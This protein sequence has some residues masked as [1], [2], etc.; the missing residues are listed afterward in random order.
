M[1]SYSPA[2]YFII[3]LNGKK[4]FVLLRSKLKNHYYAKMI[5]NIN[6]KGILAANEVNK[7]TFPRMSPPTQ[8]IFKCE[9]G[10]MLVF[11]SG[12]FRLM[13]VKE[14]LTSYDNLPFK[15]AQL[16]LQSATVVDDLGYSLNLI[17]LSR[18]LTSRRCCYEPELFPGL[19][20]TDFNPLC[21]N[22]FASGKVIILGVKDLNSISDL[23]TDV[24][25]A[26]LDI[27]L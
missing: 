26:V 19:R 6:Y 22:V 24:Q 2:L 18:T 9:V 21:V 7:I 4:V 13:G 16:E 17:D 1:H 8:R 3:F 20:L 14:P 11:Q 12:K 15:V 10:K 5:T 23:C 27:I 25:L